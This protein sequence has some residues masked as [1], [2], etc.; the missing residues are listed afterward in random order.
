M[1]VQGSAGDVGDAAAV[2]NG[3]AQE[4]LTARGRASSCSYGSDD[5]GGK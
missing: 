4:P 3:Q 2:G 1:R 5:G